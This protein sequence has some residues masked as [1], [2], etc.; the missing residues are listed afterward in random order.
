MK[1]IILFLL[2]AC[3]GITG[4]QSAKRTT[5]ISSNVKGLIYNSVSSSYLPRLTTVSLSEFADGSEFLTYKTETY[6]SLY[7]VPQF[8]VFSIPINNIDDHRVLL[9]K[10]LEWDKKALSRGDMFTKELG[11]AKAYNGY[12]NYTFHSGNKSNNY[13]DIC[14]SMV[15]SSGCSVESVAFDTE[16]VKNILND[17]D[18][19]KSGKI[20]HLDDSVYK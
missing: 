12:S 2:I 11:R 13:L 8:I 17:I 15:D 1:K 10:F 14:F 19:I 9:E 16:N 5:N 7:G 3:M 6:E 18:R 4:C 20:K